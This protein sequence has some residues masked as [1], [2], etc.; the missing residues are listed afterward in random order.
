MK[1][2]KTPSPSFSVTLKTPFTNY[3]ELMAAGSVI[4][5]LPSSASISAKINAG[6]GNI[7]TVNGNVDMSSDFVG[8][9]KI[10][11]PIKGFSNIGMTVKHNGGLKNFKSDASVMFMD[12]KEIVANVAFNLRRMAGS[13]KISTPFQGFSN[14]AMSF[15]HTGD[16]ENFDSEAKVMYMDNHEISAGLLE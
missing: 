2:A 8:S 4:N 16:M 15:K 3:E 5:N 13:A 7:A 6:N 1:A 9:L 14:L 12:D 11:T 10:T